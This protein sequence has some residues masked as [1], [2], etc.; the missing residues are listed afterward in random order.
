MKPSN[1]PHVRSIARWRDK[2]C[3]RLNRICTEHDGICDD[4]L[5]EDAVRKRDMDVFLKNIMPWLN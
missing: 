3:A 5:Q 2:W 4:G 1:C